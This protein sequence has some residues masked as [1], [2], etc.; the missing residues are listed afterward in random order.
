MRA[1]WQEVKHHESLLA[2]CVWR[3]RP[4]KVDTAMTITELEAEMSKLRGE[5]N[6]HRAQASAIDAQ[7][8]ELKK[9]WAILSTEN[10][11]LFSDNKPKE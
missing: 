9:Q 2:Q 8:D 10:L 1:V 3:G 5:A 4:I 11:P 7:A 6:W